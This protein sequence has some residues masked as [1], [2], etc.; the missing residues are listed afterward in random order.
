MS[1]HHLKLNLDQM[2]L[3][4]LPRA[5]CPFQYL[6]ITV[7]NSMLTASQNAKN[8]GVT[9]DNTLPFYAKIKSV[10]CSCRFMLYNFRR[11][12]PYRTQEVAQVL[13]PKTTWEED[14]FPESPRQHGK[15]MHSL[16]LQDNM[17][18]GFIP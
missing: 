17:G 4:F 11:V 13:I 16:S 18:R 3:L 9:L 2:E 12:R 10:T 15:R 6:Y 1:A 7:D 14:L 5:A 8:L